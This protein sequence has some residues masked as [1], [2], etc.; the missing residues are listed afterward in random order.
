T[1]PDREDP[2]R[3]DGTAV[4]GTMTHVPDGV[5]ADLLLV[6]V[7]PAT[8]I[9]IPRAAPGIAVTPL[10]T[11]DGSRKFATV[12]CSGATGTELADVG[13]ALAAAS[14][15]LALAF[16]LD[17]VGAAERALEMAVDYAK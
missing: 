16:V 5:A 10:P 9:A 1:T 12:T 15:R 13:A 17:G 2:V 6:A 4:H 8:V 3:H 7:D 11:V 14:D